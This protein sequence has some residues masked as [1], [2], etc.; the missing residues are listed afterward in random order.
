[1]LVF[2][3]SH[4]RLYNW[5]KYI[6]PSIKRAQTSPGVPDAVNSW[7]AWL[8]LYQAFFAA[9]RYRIWDSWSVHPEACFWI[10]NLLINKDIHTVLEFGS[11]YSTIFL[12]RFI[13]K[14][15]LDA[16]IES[17]EHQR[18]FREQLITRLSGAEMTT[19]HNAPLVQFSDEV[20]QQM[21]VPGTDVFAIFSRT[22][23]PVPAAQYR[24]TRLRNTFYDYGFSALP[25][26]SID[27][28]VLDGPN[29]NG[30]SIA[31]ALLKNKISIPGWIL[32]DDYRDHPYLEHLQILF[33]IEIICQR[34][35]DGKEFLLAKIINSR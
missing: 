21:F 13:H 29:G 22:K 12:D 35:V 20:F 32:I 19:I 10:A 23:N 9:N 27:L 16:K 2:R 24:E 28:I 34:E 4:R 33:D 17:F 1:V 7:R 6:L 30:R 18:E 15:R 3:T 8:V 11:G 25:E 14:M 26:R 31:F 5:Q